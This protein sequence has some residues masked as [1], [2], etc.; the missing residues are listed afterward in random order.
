ME[1]TA[2]RRRLDGGTDKHKNTSKDDTTATTKF[3]TD[4]GNDG[5]NEDSSKG[6]DGGHQTKQSASG[7]AKV[8]VRVS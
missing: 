8:C 3:I 6:V 5:Q 2:L 7:I 1:L 4:E